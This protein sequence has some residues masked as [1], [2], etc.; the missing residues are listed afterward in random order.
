MNTSLFDRAVAHA[1]AESLREIR[2]RGFSP[3][4]PGD[5]PFD[6]EPDD[7]PPQCVDWD[8][9]DAERGGLFP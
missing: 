8:A 2:R 4:D 7:S 1:T 3:V 5:A 6:P 9:L